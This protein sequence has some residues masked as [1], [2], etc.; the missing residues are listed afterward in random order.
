M[1]S[2]D[3]T[4]LSQWNRSLNQI[5][6]E[7][8]PNYQLFSSNSPLTGP[9][10]ERRPELLLRSKGDGISSAQ[11]GFGIFPQSKSGTQ[12]WLSQNDFAETKGMAWQ[13]IDLGR[14]DDEGVHSLTAFNL[15]DAVSVDLRYSD[16]N[17]SS[18]A[19]YH[20]AEVSAA[21]HFSFRDSGLS[22]EGGLLTEEKSFLGSAS[23]GP[24]SVNGAQ[25]QFLRIS[26]HHRLTPRVALVGALTG[27][28][29]SVSEQPNTL[30][31][32]FSTMISDAWLFGLAAKSILHIGDS[33]SITFA[34]PLRVR[35]GTADLDMAYGLSAD[36]EILRHEQRLD[37]QPSGVETLMEFV[38]RVPWM[39]SWDLGAYVS[40]RSQPNHISAAPLSMDFLML[41]RSVF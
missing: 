6:L 37:L 3:L 34:Q 30:M 33:M 28:I 7:D 5:L 14:Y 16:I 20:G 18:E 13:R 40:L 9:S 10:S 8:G 36:G 25:S 38:Y 4:V 32:N 21:T 26:G 17:D 2:S 29:S 27:A 41:A 22:L 23:G 19:D 15:T 1:C 31:Q 39:T 35:S 24:L 11:L 12:A